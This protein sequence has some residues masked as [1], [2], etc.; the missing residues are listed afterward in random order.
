M[1]DKVTRKSSPPI[2]VYCLPS[3][4]RSIELQAKKAGLSAAKYL[5]D[6]GQ[7]YLITSVVDFRAVRELARI[8]GDLGRLGGLL[9][10][11]LSNDARTAHFDHATLRA[12]LNMVE[13]NQLELSL[14]IANL[15][16][17]HGTLAA[18]FSKARR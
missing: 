12:V 5:R 9:K 7:G 15:V 10:L 11:W 17:P 14:A 4:K 3:E 16:S 2:K 6:V 13:E 1:T 8:N 18:K